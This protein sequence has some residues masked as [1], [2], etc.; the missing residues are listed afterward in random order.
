MKLT[1]AYDGR[2]YLGW[3]SQTGGNTVQDLINGALAEVAKEPIRIQGSGRTDTGVHALGQIAHFDPPAGS[4]MNPYNWVPALNTK[5]PATIRIMECEEVSA[6]FHSR[7]SAAGKKYFYD[8]C[9]DPVLPP[10][11]SGLAWHLPRLLD[12]DVLQQA[13]RLFEGRHDFHAFAAYRGNEQEDTDYV[14][15]VFSA[16]LETLADGYRLKFHGD[17]FLY[18]MVRMLAGSSIKA[19]QGRLRLDDLER[20]LDQPEGLPHGKAPLCAPPDGLFLE[21]VIYPAG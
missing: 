18:K 2:P 7:F 20:L 17:G 5:L 11:K 19:A 9:T 14:R 4:S 3:Q 10:L 15:E 21:Q 6:D 12:A 13:L 1:I 8:V 16:E